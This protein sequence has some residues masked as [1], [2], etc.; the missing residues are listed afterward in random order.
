MNIRRKRLLATLLLAVLLGIAIALILI[1][2]PL[3]PVR[4]RTAPVETGTLHP[5]AF[6]IATIEARRRYDIGPNRSGRL[7]ELRVDHG[8]PVS[9]GEVIGAMD[10]VDLRDRLRAAG[11]AVEA[12]EHTV[13]A[14]QARQR[15]LAQRVQLARDEAHR[16]R[17]L[18]RKKQI[19]RE[20]AEAK[21]TTAGAIAE[22]YH[23]AGADVEAARRQLD[24]ARAERD[25][26]Q[27]LLD[28]LLLR[29]PADGVVI[30]RR[31]EPGS[32]VM[33]GAPV[34]RIMDP[35]T[36][37]V[38]TRID[39]RAA[40]HLRLSLPAHIRLRGRARTLPGKVARIEWI[41]DSLTEERW[42]DVAFDAIPDDLA[43]GMLAE[44]SIELPIIKNARWLPAAA[45][46]WREGQAGAWVLKNG[47]ARFQAL[48]IG[49]RDA[50]GKIQLTGGLTAGE[51]VI[52]YS[53]HRLRDGDRL[54]AR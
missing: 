9:R 48:K 11:N 33:A 3:A 22:Q 46:H 6:G 10:P 53:A 7:L 8:D 54:E 21:A 13:E 24:K 27:A 34:V 5:R 51:R 16:Y 42:V 12:A 28:D 18:L 38:R 41:A 23:A 45:L 25:G 14:A 40:R 47:K 43:I 50:D 30:E 1:K 17:T 4:V 29:S 49:A 44:V 37:W 15:E 36:L 31:V 52:V 2:G 32:V 19:S 39:Q 20:A 35:D 26:I